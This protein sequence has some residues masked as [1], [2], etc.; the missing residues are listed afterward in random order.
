ME[1]EFEKWWARKCWAFLEVT[2]QQAREIF[3][4]GRITGIDQALAAGKG[5]PRE[6]P[7][8]GSGALWGEQQFCF[9]KGWK[10]GRALLRKSIRELL[11]ERDV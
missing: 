3:E 6:L 2:E 8:V 1:T 11:G 4:A 10:E 5:K 7:S 9:E